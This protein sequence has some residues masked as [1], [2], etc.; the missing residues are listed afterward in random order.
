MHVREIMSCPVIAATRQTTVREAA[1]IMLRHG[2]GAL[3]VLVDNRPAGIVTDRD[4]VVRLLSEPGPAGDRHVADA[5][6]PEPACCHADHNI[7][8]AAALMGDRQVRRI[9][10]LDRSG[11]L[12][13]I[14]SVGDIAENASE[15]LAGQA[16]GEISEERQT[17]RPVRPRPPPGFPG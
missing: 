3:P 1:A 2:I 4:I 16:L 15:E 13:G 6:T 17:P 8:E 7:A 12:V 9:L 5:M 10:V 14:L 11:A